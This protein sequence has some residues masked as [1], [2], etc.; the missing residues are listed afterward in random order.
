M[1]FT[2]SRLGIVASAFVVLAP[3]TS[4]ATLDDLEL[5]F[6]EQLPVVL[7]VSRMP[8]MRQD[9][10]GAIT[11]IDAD[12]IQATGYRSVGRLL[13]LVPGMQ[14]GQER[15][16]SDW[17]TYH[18]LGKDY[19]NQTQILI[20]GLSVHS[21]GL[22]TVTHTSALPLSILDIERIE[23]LRGSDFAAYGSNGFLGL[24]NIIS[25]HTDQE[26]RTTLRLSAG[27]RGVADVIARTSTRFEDGGFRVTLQSVSDDGFRELDD[28]L[29]SNSVNLRTDFRVG[30]SS[31]LKLTA[32]H[33]EA[34]RGLGYRGTVFNGSGTRD[35]INR[36]S[37]ARLK[38]RH[39]VSVT[40]EFILSF[41]HG[42]ERVVDE[43]TV[44]SAPWLS[45][46]HDTVTTSVDANSHSSWS[47]L[48]FHHRV[49]PM[50]NIKAL[51]G[52]ELRRDKLDAPSLFYRLGPQ[53]RSMARLFG[54][55]EW[56]VSDQLLLNTSAL[57]ERFEGSN[58]R[59]APRV[60]LIMQ[61]S[62]AR[63]WRL[64]FSRAYHQP[65]VFEHRT[66][67]RVLAPD[68][69]ILQ[70]RH[71]PNPDIGAQRIDV[72]ETGVFGMLSD[73]G[74]YDVRLFHERIKGLIRRMPITVTPDDPHPLNA[75]I[76][77]FIGSSRWENEPDLVRLNGLE[78]EW[79]TPQWHGAQFILTHSMV[80]AQSARKSVRNSVAPYTASLTWL[81]DWQGWHSSASLIRRGAMDASTGFLPAYDY[82]VPAFTQLDA[83]VWRTVRLGQTSADIRLTGLN[84]LG[85]HQEVA[86][87]P[88]QRISGS[89][90]LNRAGP[91]VYATVH[92][93][94]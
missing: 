40:E 35:E 75:Q 50:E 45:P 28:S 68:G 20:D 27:T 30:D 67:A 46:P 89:K 94:F 70:Q 71:V 76:Q 93:A 79:R 26:D 33:S 17:I 73:K 24:I 11:V 13:R 61:P 41:Q 7:S 38:W 14:V 18:G 90:Q 42:R 62:A 25:R 78:Y 57:V 69:R 16:N 77:S 51:W 66:D 29:R 4:F 19:P 63:S 6:L 34:R 87:N 12:L 64:G 81:Q 37:I 3:Q 82:V 84:L 5:P 74:S 15:G 86:H 49:S 47:S 44:T 1:Q 91:T 36:N 56:R 92:F 10:P 52:G 2:S 43:W 72:L 59:F 58:P 88:L 55:I 54:N 80:R 39:V 8:V 21:P 60:F 83:S 31:E 48:E 22:T 9:A 53:R 23:V 32:G 65:S 85:R